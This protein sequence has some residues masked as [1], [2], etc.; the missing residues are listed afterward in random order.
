MNKFFLL[1]LIFLISCSSDNSENIIDSEYSGIFTRVSEDAFYVPASV[2]LTLNNGTFEG[3]SSTNNY[4]AICTGTYEVRDSK[5]LFSNSCAFTADFDW[6]F[7]LDGEFD[8]ELD[9][10]NITIVREYD[11]NNY[12]Q[13]ILTKK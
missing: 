10:D 11:A 7:I 6:N 4:P 1:S 2:T 12:D 3:V 13:Y 8:F 9:G 5:I